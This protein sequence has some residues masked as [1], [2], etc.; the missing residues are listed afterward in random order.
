MNF[1]NYFLGLSLV[2]S[3]LFTALTF[4]GAFVDVDFLILLTAKFLLVAWR[5]IEAALV[6][7]SYEEFV[8]EPIRPTSN[9]AG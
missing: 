4:L 2:V 6:K 5:A 7:S 9:F 1:A 8:Q 3:L